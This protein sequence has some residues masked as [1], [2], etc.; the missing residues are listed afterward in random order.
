MAA[1][2]SV[3]NFYRISTSIIIFIWKSQRCMQQNSS[4]NILSC[5]Y[6][7]IDYFVDC[8]LMSVIWNVYIDIYRITLAALHYNENGMRDQAV[9]KAWKKRYSIVYPKFKKGGYT[10]R[11]VK[12]NCTFCKYTVFIMKGKYMININSILQNMISVSNT[13]VDLHD[14]V[15]HFNIIN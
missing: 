9:T 7:E 2:R 1:T 4:K 13:T 14:F 11:E 6:A 3:L 8:P 15:S 5:F 12:V 10:V